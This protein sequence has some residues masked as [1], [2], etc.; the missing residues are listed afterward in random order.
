M[1]SYLALGKPDGEGNVPPSQRINLGCVGVGGRAASVIPG[2][3][4]NGFAQPVA[5]CDV[6]LNARNIEKNL[7]RYPGAKQFADFRIM[8]DKMGKDIDAV[9][10]VTP[11]HTHYV[12][13]IAAMQLGKHVYVEKPLTHTYREADLLMQAEKKYKVVTQMGN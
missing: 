8:L 5:L 9:S 3:C 11:D 13:A 4:T 12:A 10:V 7:E 6:D 1:P 2:L